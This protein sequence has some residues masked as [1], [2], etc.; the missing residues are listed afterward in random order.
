M[1]CDALQSK[2]ALRWISYW[3]GSAFI[4]Q[5]AKKI[6]SWQGIKWKWSFTS[7]LP[8]HV[9]Q[10]NC[11]MRFGTSLYYC[12]L[13]CSKVFKVLMC[14]QLANLTGFTEGKAS[15]NKSSIGNYSNKNVLLWRLDVIHLCNLTT[16]QHKSTVKFSTKNQNRLILHVQWTLKPNGCKE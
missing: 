10:N 6:C 5:A 2:I 4:Q 9:W 12:Y 13:C 14:I 16:L 15:T 7:V 3:T 11:P 1:A 8:F